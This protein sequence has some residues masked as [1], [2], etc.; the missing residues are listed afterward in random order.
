MSLP[1]VWSLLGALGGLVGAWALISAGYH[2][3]K[4]RQYTRRTAEALEQLV[5]REP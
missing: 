5:K 2:N 1:D 3:Y 4:M